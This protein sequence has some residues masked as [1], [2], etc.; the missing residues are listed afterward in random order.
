LWI[1]KS[2]IAL[3]LPLLKQ[4]LGEQ[5]FHNLCRY[6]GEHARISKSL[7]TG[8]ESGATLE[9]IQRGG[10][11]MADAKLGKLTLEISREPLQRIIGEGG[12]VAL[13][14][15]ISKL[16]A[17]QIAAQLVDHVVKEGVDSGAEPRVELDFVIDSGGGFGTKPHLPYF[18][19]T[20]WGPDQGPDNRFGV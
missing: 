10:M 18:P 11:D 14:N 15:T 7:L 19:V 6:L 16:A 9:T 20:H 3:C 4:S 5:L 17:E 13:T 12:L 1:V 2:D 8:P